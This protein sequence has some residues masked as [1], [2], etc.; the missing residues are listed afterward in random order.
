MATGSINKTQD[1][2]IFMC[3]IA[4]DRAV[5]IFQIKELILIQIIQSKK[6]QLPR[7]ITS[8]IK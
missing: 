1:S 8:L 5:K 4:I 3:D 6:K 7:K 2:G